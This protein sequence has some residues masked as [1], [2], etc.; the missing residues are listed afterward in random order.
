MPRV[1]FEPTIPA[2][3]R[4]KTLHALEHAATV[5]DSLLNGMYK[6]NSYLMGNTI[7]PH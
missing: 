3:K 4:T 2:S 5:T 1:G 6:L 7:R